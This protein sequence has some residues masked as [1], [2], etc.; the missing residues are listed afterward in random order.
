MNATTPTQW[1][2]SAVIYQIYPRSFQDSTGNGVGDLGGITQRLD[3]L[4][5]TLGVDAIWISPIFPSP[6]ADFG[7]DISDYT[8]VDPMFGTLDDADTLIAEAH[9]LGL[10]VIMDWVPNHSS[11]Q[12]AWFK[13]SRA[14]LASPKRDWYVWAEPDDEG[15]PPNNWLSLFGGPAW[16]LDD[17]TQQYYLHSFLPEQPDLNWRNP[18]VVDA[19]MDTLR[20]WLDRGVDGFRVDVAHFMA[21]DPLMRSNP[22]ATGS[23]EGTKT[24]NEYDTQ[25]HVYDKGHTDIHTMHAAI[26]AVLDEYDDRFGIGEV[27]ESDWERWAMYYGV[28]GTG[29]HMPFN[30]SLLWASWDANDFRHKIMGQESALPPGAWGNHVLGNHDEPRFGTRFGPERI[31]AAA[32]LLL[33]LRGTPT[34]YYGEE[35]GLVDCVVEP[36]NEQDP[37]GKSYPEL[38]RD[39]CRSPMQWTGDPGMGFT[40]ATATPWLPFAD[41]STSVA[42][43]L[44]DPTSTLSLYRTLLELRRSTEALATGS[45]AMLTANKDHVLSFSRT[46]GDDTVYVAVNFTDAQQPFT[47][48]QRV[49]QVVGTAGDRPGEFSEVL[50][51]PNEALVAR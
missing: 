45:I 17:A 40:H 22:P 10:K 20:F 18:V 37:W 9:R 16:T 3:Y 27:H 42:D 31:R 43:Q 48:P 25:D 35:L 50:L 1:W 44:G 29:L 24:L 49:T 30:F 39:G 51:D 36:G 28:N 8:N 32:V 15:Q 21:K 34:L 12:H 2:K 14:S 41:A 33:T 5:N 7:Y 4:S 26:R 46:S 11:D 6:M 47:F 13:E 19:M 23:K 38:N